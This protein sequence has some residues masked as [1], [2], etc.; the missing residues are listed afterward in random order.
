M[1]G[2]FAGAG[3]ITTAYGLFLGGKFLYK[4]LFNRRPGRERRRLKRR[5]VNLM[6]DE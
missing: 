5:V 4:K 1:V 6:L 2:F 3:L